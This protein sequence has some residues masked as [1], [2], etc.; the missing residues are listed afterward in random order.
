MKSSRKGWECKLAKYGLYDTRA[1]LNNHDKKK[2]F[3][4]DKLL[5]NRD[6]CVEI[7]VGV[8]LPK[9]VSCLKS[10]LRP[11][12]LKVSCLS[13]IRHFFLEIVLV[14]VL[15]V[16]YLDIAKYRMQRCSNHLKMTKI[17]FAFDISFI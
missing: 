2:V 11:V 15:I 1:D 10:V 16:S 5:H 4:G 3:C 9:K 13:L 6:D 17:T 7:P 14:L 8:L 12:P